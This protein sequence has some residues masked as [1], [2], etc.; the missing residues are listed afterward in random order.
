MSSKQIQYTVV[1]SDMNPVRIYT[2]YDMF[3]EHSAIA[4]QCRLDCKVNRGGTG[5]ETVFVEALNVTVKVTEG[6]KGELIVSEDTVT[7][8]YSF[9]A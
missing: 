3:S 2:L 1:G 9:T 4:D 7:P 6:E 5:S 8:F